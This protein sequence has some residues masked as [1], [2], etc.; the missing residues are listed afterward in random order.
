VNA[1]FLCPT[2]L[3][4]STI[5]KPLFSN[6]LANPRRNAAEFPLPLKRERVQTLQILV[7]HHDSAGHDLIKLNHLIPLTAAY[8]TPELQKPH[9]KNVLPI[10]LRQSQQWHYGFAVNRTS[11]YYFGRY[12]KLKSIPNVFCEYR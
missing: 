1:R 10:D 11:P 6:D 2:A 8:R 4:I 3:D 12:D 9:D 7:L 5:W